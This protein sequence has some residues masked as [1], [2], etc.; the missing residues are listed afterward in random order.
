M[1]SGQLKEVVLVGCHLAN[2]LPASYAGL[3]RL[4]LVHAFQRA[5][6]SLTHV[7]NLVEVLRASPELEELILHRVPILPPDS[8]LDLHSHIATASVITLPRLRYLDLTLYPEL[9]TYLLARFRTSPVLYA[10]VLTIDIPVSFEERQAEEYLVEVKDY[11]LCLPSRECF[12]MLSTIGGLFIHHKKTSPSINRYRP[13]GKGPA[14]AVVPKSYPV[15]FLFTNLLWNVNGDM[16]KTLEVA[17]TNLFTSIASHHHMPS[18]S[19]VSIYAGVGSCGEPYLSPTDLS[20]VVPILAAAPNVAYLEVIGFIQPTGPV[21]VFLSCIS[22]APMLGEL[23]RLLFSTCDLSEQAIDQLA[24]GITH[25][26]KLEM[27]ELVHYFS[28]MDVVDVK[29][30][31]RRDGLAVRCRSVKRSWLGI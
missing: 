2:L 29:R 21:E 23:S 22:S 1:P 4:S 8:L 16:H 20:H 30:R 15:P 12:P 6:H 19:R 24:E 25:M 31:L 10:L 7:V 13:P 27:L 17:Y 5:S 3:T 26:P 28:P 11:L 9:M 18:L 14:S